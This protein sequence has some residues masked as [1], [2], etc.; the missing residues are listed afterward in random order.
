MPNSAL[1]ST[2]KH[3]LAAGL[4]CSQRCQKSGVREQK[5]T[6]PPQRTTPTCCSPGCRSRIWLLSAAATPA[7]SPS[8][9]A[10]DSGAPEALPLLV[11]SL[12]VGEDRVLVVNAGGLT[13]GAAQRLGARPEV[14]M[15]KTADLHR[16]LPQSRS[17]RDAGPAA[18]LR[19]E[20]R[21]ILLCLPPLTAPGFP[22]TLASIA[23]GSVL[24][25]PW[26]K[27]TPDLLQQAVAAHGAALRP[28]LTTV[29]TGAD[30]SRARSY[31]RRGDYEERL[32][33]A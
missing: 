5:S 25:V 1:D 20:F 7:A 15:W 27:V 13:P 8:A 4:G 31:M 16:I 24:L 10:N 6:F 32:L 22:A 11:E 29:L 23:D 9:S 17:G 26:G 18:D 14:E 3:Q 30:L 19:A 2:L 33:H 28:I 21:H 12:A